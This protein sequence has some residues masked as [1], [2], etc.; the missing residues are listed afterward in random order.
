M[1]YLGREGQGAGGKEADAHPCWRLEEPL[2]VFLAS[3]VGFGEEG[4]MPRRSLVQE[5]VLGKGWNEK[6]DETVE[7]CE[8]EE[9]QCYRPVVWGVI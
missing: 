7:A 3:S 8:V 6:V 5:F 9:K 2:V 1:T 4:S